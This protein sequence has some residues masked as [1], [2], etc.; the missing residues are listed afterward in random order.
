MTRDYR[1]GR[2]FS[3]RYRIFFTILVLLLLVSCV[4]RPAAGPGAPA[5]P[6]AGAEADQAAASQSQHILLI[7]SLPGAIIQES[8]PYQDADVYQIEV[9]DLRSGEPVEAIAPVEVGVEMNYAFSPDHTRL[10]VTSKFAGCSGLCLR[11]YELS[12]LRQ[13][14]KVE[15]P[16]TEGG[17]GY[18][19]QIVFDRQ[20]KRI[21]VTYIADGK[22]HLALVDLPSSGA[23]VVEE[24]NFSY[25]PNQMSFSGDGTR[26]MIVAHR[27]P[28]DI[29]SGPEVSPQLVALLWDAQTLQTIW[30]QELTEVKDGF[31]GSQDHSKPEENTYYQAGIAVD[32]DRQKIYLAHAD[33]DQLTTVDFLEQ[34]VETVAIREKR[35]WYEDLIEAVLSM[36]VRRVQAKAA[37]SY[38][39]QALLSADGG[40]LYV[41]GIR[42]NLVKQD[43][44]NYER[45]HTPYGLAG[46]ELESA[47]RLFQVETDASEL[48]RGLGETLILNGYDQNS[49]E[50]RPFTEVFELSSGQKIAHFQRVYAYPTLRT[51]GSP[52]LVSVYTS[53]RGRTFLSVLKEDFQKSG[54]LWEKTLTQGYAF[55]PELR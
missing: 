2:F 7:Q 4:P 38:H 53:D 37:N 31:Y 24:I 11:V 17:Q 43:N 27:L 25:S 32:A 6:E 28:E 13:T 16:E 54:L 52:A 42:Y 50:Y 44:G 45:V 49:R 46:W 22:G 55:W 30:E 36:G 33:A 3:S 5:R 21:A 40:I 26:L 41:V 47:R 8:G 34:R 39:R 14:A 48:R 51:D 9:I 10:A 15:L 19:S 29:P 20:G 1:A 12:N 18:A 35:A 23:P